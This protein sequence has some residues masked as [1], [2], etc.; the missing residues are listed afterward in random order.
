[1]KKF[2]ELHRDN[3][4]GDPKLKYL[5]QKILGVML[6]LTDVENNENGVTKIGKTK[7]WI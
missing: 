6:F 7:Q 3:I 5:I 2:V 4:Q 1:M